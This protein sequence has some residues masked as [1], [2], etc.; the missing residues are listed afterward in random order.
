MRTMPVEVTRAKLASDVETLR[1]LGKA[2][3]RARQKRLVRERNKLRL[4]LLECENRSKE[5][6]EDI[7]PVDD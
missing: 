3:A 6:H 1:R 5:A 2:G 7:C 4:L